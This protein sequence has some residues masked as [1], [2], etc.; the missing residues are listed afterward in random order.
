LWAAQAFC[1]R[2][3]D[4]ASLRAPTLD[5]AFQVERR[6]QTH[7]AIRNRVRPSVVLRVLKLQQEGEP[8]DQRLFDRV[9]ADLNI[10]GALA[11]SIFYDNT[12]KLWR[13]KILRN[14]R[15]S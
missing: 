6:K 4:W 11:K 12:S 2:F 7:Q 10:S 8:T 1:D 9:G 15:I 3:L 5:V 13:Q 14:A